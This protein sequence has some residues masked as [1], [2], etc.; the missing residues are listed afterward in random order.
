MR[1]RRAVQGREQRKSPDQAAQDDRAVAKRL[2]KIAGDQQRFITAEDRWAAGFRA[3]LCRRWVKGGKVQTEQMFSGLCLKAEARPGSGPS[4]RADCRCR[5]PVISLTDR[6]TTL[7]YQT[8]VRRWPALSQMLIHMQRLK[9]HD[10]S[11]RMS[12]LI[13]GAFLLAAFAISRLI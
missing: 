1:S 4:N 10:R 2:A 13:V 11:N 12:E 5:A 7:R 6:K 8:R 9:D 3:S